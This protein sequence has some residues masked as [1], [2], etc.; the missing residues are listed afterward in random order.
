MIG[1]RFRKSIPRYLALRLL[2]PRWSASYTGLASQV[3]LCEVPSPDLP[4]SDW[5]RVRPILSGI[6]GSDLATICAKGSAYFSP[7]TSTPF[8]LGHEVVGAVSEVGAAV[9]EFSVGDRVVLQPALGCEVRG[10]EPKCDACAAGRAALCRNVTRGDISAG[11]QTGFCRDTGGAWSESFVAHRSQLH[12]VPE[13]IDDETAVLTEPFACAIHGALRAHCAP[14]STVLVVGCGSIGLLTIAAL[15][16]LQPS[17]RII[18]VAK[19]RHQQEHAQRLGA[20]RIISYA[21]SVKERYERIADALNADLHFPEIGNPTVIGGAAATFDCVASSGSIDDCCRFTRA[22]GQMV[23]VGMP[24]I[25]VG[26][27]WTAIWYKELTLR[28]AYA[29]GC[30][31]HA[32]KSQTTFEMSIELLRKIGSQLRPLVGEPFALEDY[33]RAVRA[34]LRTGASGSIKTVFRIGSRSSGGPGQ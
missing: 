25:P 18:A 3:S 11:I 6:C 24:A 17:V 19:H 22:G 27:D 23:L 15:R 7:L 12:A 26:I 5:V 2:G 29:Y 28:A 14:E 16:A 21:R 10:I 8:V 34:A 13:G 32:G 20:D 4:T 31:E 9:A 30:E 1:I 33:R